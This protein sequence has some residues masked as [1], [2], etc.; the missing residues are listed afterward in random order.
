[1]SKTAKTILAEYLSW[2]FLSFFTEK[3][4]W[5]SSLNK[6]LVRD[7]LKIHALKF[8]ENFH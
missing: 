8:Y 1:M 6:W 2:R 4:N 3:T 7:V 5:K